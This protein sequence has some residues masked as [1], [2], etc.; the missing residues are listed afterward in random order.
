MTVKEL[1][2]ILNTLPDD[3]IVV[4]HPETADNPYIVDL[5]VYSEQDNILTLTGNEIYDPEDYEDDI[6]DD[7]DESNYDLTA[8]VIS[9]KAW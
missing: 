6:P 4:Y 3:T 1:I 9:N 5:S 2:A 8:G 7:V